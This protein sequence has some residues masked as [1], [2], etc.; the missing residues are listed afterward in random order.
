MVRTT[1]TPEQRDNKI[2]KARID[3][4]LWFGKEQAKLW[5]AYKQKCKR[6]HIVPLNLEHERRPPFSL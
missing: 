4:E 6:R 1:G 3:T 2:L 5:N